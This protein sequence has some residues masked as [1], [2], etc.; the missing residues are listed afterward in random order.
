MIFGIFNLVIRIIEA[1][2]FI[3]III[4]WIMPQNRKNEFVDFIN[5]ITE[6]MLAPFRIMMPLGKM[7]GL[8]LSPIVLLILLDVLRSVLFRIL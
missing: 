5:G 7:G 8:D 1:L 3:R 2:I 6:P 4:S